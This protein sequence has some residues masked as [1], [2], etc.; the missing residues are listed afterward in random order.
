[1]HDDWG[2]EVI[3]M[4]ATSSETQDGDDRES[5]TQTC[6]PS[7]VIKTSM[8]RFFL[9]FDVDMMGHFCK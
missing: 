4:E 9:Y 8:N 6:H 5:F 1:M 3:V 2:I 7:Q